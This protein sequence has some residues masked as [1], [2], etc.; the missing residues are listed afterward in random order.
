MTGLLIWL[1]CVACAG[2]IRLYPLWGHLWSP[3]GEQATL[4][5]LVN[6]KKSLLEQ[7]L[8]QSPQMPLDQSDRLA[9]D[10]L[11]EVLRS[12]NARVRHAIEQANQAFA[13]QK[14]PAQDPIYLLEADPFYFYNLTENIAVKGRMADTIKGHQYFNPLMGAPH[15]YWQPLSLHPYVGFYVY[16]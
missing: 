5:V 8:A 14:G 12:D 3:T 1:V 10:K 15:G 16:K 11:N 9:S 13:R 2:Y 4:T 6:L 7:I